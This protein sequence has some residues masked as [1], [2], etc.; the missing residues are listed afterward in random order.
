M[1]RPKNSAIEVKKQDGKGK[2]ETVGASPGASAPS[3]HKPLPAPKPKISEIEARNHDAK[4]KADST[5]VGEIA[6]RGKQKS[7][8]APKSKTQA[9]A[10][11]GKGKAEATD[12]GEVGRAAARSGRQAV[13]TRKSYRL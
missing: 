3:R 6:S 13:P 5:S 10:Q 9:K 1:L 12:G 11:N 4:G 7:S 8:L 2:V